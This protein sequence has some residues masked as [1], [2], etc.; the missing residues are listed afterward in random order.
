MVT[1]YLS[2]LNIIE[3]ASLR[4]AYSRSHTLKGLRVLKFM[5]DYGRASVFPVL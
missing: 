4:G 1:S 3:L 5:Q 2:T